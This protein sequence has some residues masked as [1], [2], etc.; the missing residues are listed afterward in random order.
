MLFAVINHRDSGKLSPKGVSQALIHSLIEYA[1]RIRFSIH[2]GT[3][4]RVGSGFQNFI[5]VLLHSKVVGIQ[6]SLILLH[7]YI[8]AG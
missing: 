4:L 2:S 6:P 3:K 8:G 5:S 1:Q 7:R